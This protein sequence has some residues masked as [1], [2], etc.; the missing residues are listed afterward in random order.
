[1][2]SRVALEF[3]QNNDEIVDLVITPSSTSDD[4]SLVTQLVFVL[5]PDQCTS[6]IDPITVTLTSADPTQIVITSQTA[7]QIEATVYITA[8][9]LAVPYDRWWRV[10]AY[11]GT[12]KR[13]A[14]Y[15]PV[16]VIDL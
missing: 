16:T 4:L 6:D 9:S 13:T 15:G 7:A 10:D 14:M 12:S 1:M 5:K 2:S 3:R 8:T 11:V